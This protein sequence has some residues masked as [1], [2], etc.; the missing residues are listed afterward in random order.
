MLSIT[1]SKVGGGKTTNRSAMVHGKEC[2]IRIYHEFKAVW[3]AAGS[4][5]GKYIS[6]SEGSESAAICRWEGAARSA[7]AVPFA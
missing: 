1:D 4:Y 3:I 5:E 2:E 6:T 7:A